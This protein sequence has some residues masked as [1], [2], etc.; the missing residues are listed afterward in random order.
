MKFVVDE[1]AG[2][3]V[4][5]ELQR[6]GHDVFSIHEQSPGIEDALILNTS[7]IAG[8]VLITNDKDFGELVYRSGLPHTGVVLFRLR[9]ESATN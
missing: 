3:A 6:R 8:R 2:D 7:A 1:S 9:D 5:R 4:T